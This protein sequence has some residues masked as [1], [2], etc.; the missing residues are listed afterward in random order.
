MY[1]GYN[2]LVFIFG[3]GYCDYDSFWVVYIIN[4]DSGNYN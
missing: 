1:L 3:L 2:S 4:Y